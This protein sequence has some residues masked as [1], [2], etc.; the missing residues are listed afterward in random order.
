MGLPRHRRTELFY[1][2]HFAATPAF[3]GQID[4]SEKDVKT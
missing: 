3:K 2:A 4:A 1:D